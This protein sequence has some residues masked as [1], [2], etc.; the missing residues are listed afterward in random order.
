MTSFFHKRARP[1]SPCLPY[2][3]LVHN[4]NPL[5]VRS[6]IL[7]ILSFPTIVS[8]KKILYGSWS[9]TRTLNP[10]HLGI[11][12]S[13]TILHECLHCTNSKTLRKKTRMKIK[14][15]QLTLISQIPTKNEIL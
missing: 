7:L 6:L 4:D 15:H 3:W 8:N 13:L 1:P 5:N 12:N 14:G 11:M 9:L 10:H 2:H